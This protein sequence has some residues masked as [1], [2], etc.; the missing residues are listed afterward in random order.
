MAKSGASAGGGGE[1]YFVYVADWGSHRIQP[2]TR[3]G[4]FLDEFGGL[5]FEG[6]DG[7]SRPRGVWAPG[8]R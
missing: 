2:L 6:F 5:R 4:Q 8:H 1:K 7:L 3:E